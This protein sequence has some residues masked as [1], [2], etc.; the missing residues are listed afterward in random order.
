M[1]SQSFH[2]LKLHFSFLNVPVSVS[3][4][5]SENDLGLRHEWSKLKE[6]YL[7]GWDPATNP[8]ASWIIK[9]RQLPAQLCN[10]LA[11]R[12]LV[13]DSLACLISAPRELLPLGSVNFTPLLNYLRISAQPKLCDYYHYCLKFC[14]IHVELLETFYNFCMCLVKQVR[15][16]GYQPWIVSQWILGELMLKL[17]PQ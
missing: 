10:A 14:I 8:T 16:K 17:K 12:C 3:R 1:C 7:E 13:Q 6:A 11:G 2:F 4:R 15:P 5:I 9:Q